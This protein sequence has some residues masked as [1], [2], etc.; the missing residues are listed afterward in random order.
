MLNTLI[1]HYLK[2]Q[3]LFECDICERFQKAPRLIRSS[4]SRQK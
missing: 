2:V 3:G 4:F 1:V